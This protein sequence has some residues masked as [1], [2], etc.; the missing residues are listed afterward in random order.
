MKSSP[1]KHWPVIVAVACSAFGLAIAINAFSFSHASGSAGR[2]PSETFNSMEVT[3]TDKREGTEIAPV[4]STVEDVEAT[5]RPLTSFDDQVLKSD[6]PVLVDFYA[7]WCGPCQLQAPIFDELAGEIETAKIVT[8][9]VDDNPELATRY[10]I[11][12]IPTLLLFKNGRVVAR[13]MGL[14]SKNQV[15][16]LLVG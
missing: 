7:D 2:S 8:V 1:K 16:A 14:A 4:Q 3:P 11:S 13:H 5:V 9:N 6:V 15:K 10:Q 12:S